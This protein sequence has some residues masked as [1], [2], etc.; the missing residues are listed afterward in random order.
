MSDNVPI[1]EIRQQLARMLRSERFIRP[2]SQRRLLVFLVEQT[3]AK[4]I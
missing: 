2:D 4:D 3:L 1:P